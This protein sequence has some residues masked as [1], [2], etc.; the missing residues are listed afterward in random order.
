MTYHAHKGN[1]FNYTI[2]I[3]KELTKVRC[4]RYHT[5]GHQNSTDTDTGWIKVDNILTLFVDTLR[6]IKK[7]DEGERLT[8]E[9]QHNAMCEIGQFIN[10]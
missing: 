5:N 10:S 2:H 8:T 4:L 9:L 1:G 6:A 3:N 7:E